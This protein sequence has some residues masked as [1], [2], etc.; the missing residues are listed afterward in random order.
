MEQIQTNALLPAGK[1]IIDE[2]I[3]SLIQNTADG[4]QYWHTDMSGKCLRYY[5]NTGQEGVR[6][7]I[8]QDWITPEAVMFSLRMAYGENFDC[9]SLIASEHTPHEEPCRLRELWLVAQQALSDEENVNFDLMTYV[10]LYTS[11]VRQKNL[12]DDLCRVL[13][14]ASED[15]LEVFKEKETQ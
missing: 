8:M 11:E 13:V 6:I 4:S 5:Y 15:V 14:T 12:F 3:E 10:R 7:C 9:E 1:T 2:F